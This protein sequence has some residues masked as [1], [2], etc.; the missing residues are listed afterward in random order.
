MDYT[1]PNLTVDIVFL[2]LVEG[3]L[4]VALMHRHRAPFQ[5]N[6]ALVGGY[7]HADE[8]KDS[9][10]AAFRTAQAKLQFRPQHLEQVFTEANEHRDPRGWSA[11]IV[12]LALHSPQ[13]LAD[14][15]ARQG[16]QLFDVE[17]LPTYM[18]FDHAHLIRMAVAR[19]RTKAAYSTIVAHMMPETFT[20][21]ELQSVYEAVLNK[22]LNPSNFRRKILEL[23]S[24]EPV[25]TQHGAGRPAQSYRLNQPI[26]YFDRHLA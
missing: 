24:L 1:L 18:A 22:K 12:H 14:M 2:T 13:M 7:I 5:G 9:I 23:A 15:A 3:R 21:A 4:Q 17:Y 26:D 10:A 6:W 19:L 25:G 16:L 20:L 8:D 11:S